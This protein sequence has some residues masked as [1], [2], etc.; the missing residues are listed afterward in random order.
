MTIL[1]NR[2]SLAKF[3]D[4]WLVYFGCRLNGDGGSANWGLNAATT[5]EPMILTMQAGEL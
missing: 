1:L 5:T 2:F 4:D 3:A